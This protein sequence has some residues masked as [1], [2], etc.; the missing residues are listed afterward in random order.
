MTGKLKY[1]L[2]PTSHLT[3]LMSFMDAP[4]ANDPGGITRAQVDADREQARD[5][6]VLL[7]SGRAGDSWQARLLCIATSFCQG[8]NSQ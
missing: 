1:T 2:S 7:D 5:R 6:N 4:F 8:T 3:T